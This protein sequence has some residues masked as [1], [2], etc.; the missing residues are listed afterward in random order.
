MMSNEDLLIEKK[1]FPEHETFEGNYNSLTLIDVNVGGFLTLKG[2]F[3][4]VKIDNV[5]TSLLSISA[6]MD[7]LSINRLSCGQIVIYNNPDKIIIN[8]TIC[9]SNLE[10]KKEL[11]FLS[12]KNFRCKNFIV[13][14]P[15]K[16][17]S[18]YET[19]I[20][21]NFECNAKIQEMDAK[22]FKILG[23]FNEQLTLPVTSNAERARVMQSLSVKSGTER[24]SNTR[25]IP[26]LKSGIERFSNT[27]IF[28][29]FKAA[30]GK[31]SN[32]KPTVLNLT[33]FQILDY[34][35]KEKEGKM[36]DQSKN[37]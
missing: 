1:N 21:K 9:T 37:D 22:N 7:E 4:V 16:K 30:V 13:E 11:E 14:K 8:D 26:P 19:L 32:E 33:D 15:I 35:E 18:V 25:T 6:E 23:K 24:F 12:L 29:H 5:S 20:T 2:N 31:Y 34:L 28:S 3:K 10:S 17:L 36:M 27:P